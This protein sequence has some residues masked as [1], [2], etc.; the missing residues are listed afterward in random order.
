MPVAVNIQPLED[1]PSFIIPANEYGPEDVKIQ[2]VDKEFS[3][4]NV[5][6]QFSENL[7]KHWSRYM[8]INQFENDLFECITTYMYRR[9]SAKHLKVKRTRDPTTLRVNS[10]DGT[11]FCFLCSTPEGFEM[12]SSNLPTETMFIYDTVNS[13]IASV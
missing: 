13:K 4:S 2:F 12:V 7:G 8:E 10:S 3:Y 9:Y 6:C 11:L 1:G 5:A